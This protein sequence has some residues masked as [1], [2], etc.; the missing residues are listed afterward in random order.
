MRMQYSEAFA[1]ALR[2]CL[3]EDERVVLFGIEY[4]GI[5]AHQRHFSAL[6]A[7]YP[8]RVTNPPWSELAKA[9]AGVGAAIAGLRPVVDL[10]TASFMYHGI[11]QV[12]NEAPNVR[13]IS[14]GQTSCP[15]VFHVLGGIRRAGGAQHSHMPQAMLWN[16][17]GLH[18][19]MPATPSDAY[20]L[21]RTAVLESADPVVIVDHPLL[22]DLEQEIDVDAEPLPFGVAR[23]VREGSD[24]TVVATSVMV[25]RAEVAADALRL[26]HGV[27]IEVIDP[28]TLVP[29]DGE[30]IMASVRKTGRLVVADESHASCGVGAELM[31]RAVEQCYPDLRSAP[32][33]VSTP[34]VPIPFSAPLEEAM[35]PSAQAIVDACLATLGAVSRR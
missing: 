22:F 24:V 32:R 30:T 14:A 13:F 11:P 33:R 23:V 27:Q 16:T 2:R 31:A 12:I 1:A 3:E 17:P 35:V 7:D 8:D 26:E 15:V 9:G 19:V 6:A 28:R 29:L 18:V 4:G 21:V 5:T 10:V 25:G 34:D 20:G